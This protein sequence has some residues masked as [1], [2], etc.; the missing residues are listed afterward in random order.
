M[1]SV[2][3]LVL[4]C[5]FDVL[6]VVD[7]ETVA[8]GPYLGAADEKVGLPSLPVV[9][10]RVKIGCPTTPLWN[11][12]KVYFCCPQ[13]GLSLYPRF[14]SAADRLCANPHL[15]LAPAERA[16]VSHAAVHPGAVE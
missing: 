11:K 5:Q 7:G 1:T 16:D 2:V 10:L 8:F 6:A 15:E 12:V 3:A 4:Q 14:C 9:V 13:I